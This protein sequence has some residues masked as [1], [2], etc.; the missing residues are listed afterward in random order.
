MNKKHFDKQLSDDLYIEA[1]ADANLFSLKCLM[2]LCFFVVLSEIL[3]EIG[4]FEIPLTFM[5]ISSAIEAVILA[6][7]LIVFLVH[8]KWLK[9]P[10][11]I[12]KKKQLKHIIL[13]TT[14]ISIG[15]MC[16]TLSFHAVILLAIPPLIAAQY[17]NQKGLFTRVV[18]A[19]VILVFVGVYGSFFFGTVDRNLIRSDLTDEE[20]ESIATRF[21]IATSKRMLELFTHYVIPR[22]LC[23]IAI[24]LLVFGITHRN[25][26]M[27]EKQIELDKKVNEEIK[28]LA[29]LQSRV[30]DVLAT[31][32]ETRDVGTGEHVIRT[33]RYV[34]MIANELRKHDKYKDQL[35]D[36][37]IMRIE[38]AAP[39][40]D[41]GKIVVSDTIL[42][43]PGKL[44]PE[45]FDAMKV[46]TTK[47]RKV[48][49]D[50]FAGME[51]EEF[52]R[53]AEQIAMYH[54]EKWNGCGYPEGL[55][56]E[57]IPLSARI[58]AV[59]DVFDALVSVRVYKKAVPPEEALNI[60]M[61]ESGSHFDPDIMEIVNANLR[62]EL[63]RVSQLPLNKVS[64]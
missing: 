58:M 63:I 40:H 3:N 42:L 34:S 25:A 17:K 35:T 38:N 14:Y 16:S 39:L 49:R 2:V 19:T 62:D 26:K 30:I 54:H 43:K 47:G 57:D 44:T 8:D 10:D 52:L 41:V 28:N 18:I 21:E 22:L 23:V 36:D 29:K 31:L 32:I 64:Q 48:I 20:L 12:L 61:E 60:M 9:K 53:V 1:E 24:A 46:H 55:K 59:A 15:L 37:E 33:K 4:M 27:L 13:T 50:I 11:S 7:P 45:E 56:G 5:R 6:V 51:N